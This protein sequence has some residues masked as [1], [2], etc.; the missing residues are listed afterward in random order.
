MPEDYKIKETETE[1]EEE[2]EIEEDQISGQPQVSGIGKNQKVA[3]IVLAV[4]AVFVVIMWG[5]QFK[6][7]INSPFSYNPSET[8]GNKSSTCQGPDCQEDNEASLKIKDTDGD[9]LSDWDELYFYK[10]SPYLEDSD[11]DGFT[12]KEE[13]DSEN[14]PNCPIGRDCSGL[15]DIMSGTSGAED[16]LLEELNLQGI[17]PEGGEINSEQEEILNEILGGQ[18]NADILR[19]MLLESGMD[20]ELLN[21]ISDEDLMASY[22]EVLNVG[23]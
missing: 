19:K 9:G 17:E 22:E 2:K 3:V 6:K 5:V 20:E 12:D 15:E 10:T 21:Q 11:S 4:L 23:N 18:T 7:S 16:N 13:I 1:E 14:D 8:N